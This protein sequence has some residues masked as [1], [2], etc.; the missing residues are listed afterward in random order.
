VAQF[1]NRAKTDFFHTARDDI[2][3]HTSEAQPIGGMAAE[4]LSY[5]CSLVHT[6]ERGGA[7]ACFVV[8]PMQMTPGQKVGPLALGNMDMDSHF[9]PVVFDLTCSRILWAYF[10]AGYQKVRRFG[11][12][13]AT[14]PAKAAGS[15]AR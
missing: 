8:P 11:A 2:I 12:Y 13:A 4:L 5:A 3:S 15:A 14:V 6:T 9:K 10:F 1:G 7:M